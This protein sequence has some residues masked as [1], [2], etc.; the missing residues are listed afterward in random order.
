MAKTALVL[1]GGSL[2]SIYTS[3]VLDVFMEN[4]VEFDCV[5]AVS[6]GGLNAGNYIAKHIGR[7]ARINILHSNNANFA[8]F[9]QLLFK[10]NIFNF[11]YV[12]FSPIKD[13]YPYDDDALVNSKQRLIITATD[14]ETGESVYF[15]K[16]NNYAEFVHTLR[17]SCSIPLLCKPVSIDGMMCLDGGISDPIGVKK[18]FA[19]GYDKVVVVL[20]RNYEYRKKNSMALKTLYK[21]FYKKYPKLIA[22]L[23]DGPNRYNS[24]VEEINKIEQE[25]KI[26]VIRPTREI[27]IRVIEKDVRKLVDLYFQG[28]EDAQILL[29]QMF[30]YING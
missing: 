29:P 19:E 4:K 5:V 22:K 24:I 6:A 26:F 2:R 3:G 12:F 13:I 28:R 23:N 15:E 7:T 30:K 14:C 21:L 10:G 20:T 8:G 27:K 1:Q 9:K 18:A 25:K 16:R 11:D 17:A